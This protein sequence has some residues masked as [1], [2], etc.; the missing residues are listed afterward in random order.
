MPALALPPYAVTNTKITGKDNR[1][2]LVDISVQ[3]LTAG[4]RLMVAVITLGRV[5]MAAAGDTG[6]LA[7]EI[8]HTIITSRNN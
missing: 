6:L 2:T 3:F 8:E 7:R 5:G 4:V 1:V